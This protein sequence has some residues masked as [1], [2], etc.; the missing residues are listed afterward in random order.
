M[1]KLGVI[2][3]L[4]GVILLGAGVTLWA[5]QKDPYEDVYAHENPETGFQL[6]NVLRINPEYHKDDR[7]ARVLVNNQEPYENSDAYENP[8]TGFQWINVCRIDDLQKYNYENQILIKKDGDW[9]RLP[10]KY[11]HLIYNYGEFGYSVTDRTNDWFMYKDFDPAQNLITEQYSYDQ[12]PD[13]KWGY[14]YCKYT[15][16]PGGLYSMFFK[17]Y[18]TGEI[19][20]FDS[21]INYPMESWVTG[22][23]LVYQKFGEA[24]REN[25]IYLYDP[26]QS[27]S[28]KLFNGSLW[29]YDREKNEI[30]FV[31]NE[32]NR[33]PYVYS[34]RT[35]EIKALS[36]DGEQ[37]DA[38]YDDSF[39][40]I[41]AIEMPFK[42]TDEAIKALPLLE[43][44]EKTVFE[45]AV[46]IKGRD[47]PVRRVLTVEGKQY[48]AI[49]SLFQDFNLSLEI[50]IDY[51]DYNRKKFSLSAPDKTLVLD[52]A[53]D[54]LN[55]EYLNI[56]ATL[57]LT[58]EALA[59]LGIEVTGVKQYE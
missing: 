19:T 22:N 16:I 52:P 39:Q 12:S 56:D 35:G 34:F 28:Q 7:E 57:L 20:Y 36:Y 29:E 48:I 59:K 58:P 51:R 10:D 1:K 9:Y 50:T 5:A 54:S 46:T 53:D 45:H 32:P 38:V 33:Q 14:F 31:K 41:K 25:V 44:T 49:R 3:L 15:S 11:A 17:N 43:V 23:K 26:A 40:K 21:A 30:Q 37:V 42:L 2:I 4:C 6:T 27:K 13:G 8:E 55:R 24:E 47:Y 18:A